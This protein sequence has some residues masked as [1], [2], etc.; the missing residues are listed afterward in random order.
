MCNNS[1]YQYETQK[2]KI[3]KKTKKYLYLA[4]TIKKES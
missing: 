3:R 2:L 1:L 4:Q